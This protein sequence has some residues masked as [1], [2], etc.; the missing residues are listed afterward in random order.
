MQA[1]CEKDDD[2]AEVRRVANVFVDAA[3]VQGL[4][5]ADGYVG[6]EGFA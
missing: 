5:F 1:D 2:Q 6:A 4:R 3:L